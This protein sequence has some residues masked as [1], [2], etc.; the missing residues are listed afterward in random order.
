M[1]GNCEFSQLSNLRNYPAKSRWSSQCMAA[2]AEE[3]S[4]WEGGATRGAV[5]NG[6]RGA[7]PSEDYLWGSRRSPLRK[8]S[9]VMRAFGLD[10]MGTKTYS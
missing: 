5:I 2:Q 6:A 8:T 7:R 4:Q 9:V 10:E 3:T 1:G